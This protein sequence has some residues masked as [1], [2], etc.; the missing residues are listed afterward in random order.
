MAKRRRR[1]GES[2]SG[3]FRKIFEDRP[4][5]LHSKSNAEL[6]DRWNADHPSKP[7]TNRIR[8]NLANTKSVLR[9]KKRRGG[10]KAAA[11][12]GGGV[13]TGGSR[14]EMLEEHIDDALSMAKHLDREGLD[15]VIKHLRSARNEVVWKLGQ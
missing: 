7:A 8:Q 4:E 5:L 11:A 1:G 12:M 6:I 9:R 10:R 13:T 14:L 2:I 15:S 3:Y